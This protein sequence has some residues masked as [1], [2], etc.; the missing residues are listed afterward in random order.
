MRINCFCIPY[1][2][3]AHSQPCQ[4]RPPC[5]GLPVNS[6]PRKISSSTAPEPPVP[7][8]PRP[9]AA[10]LE[11]LLA[12]ALALA[13]VLGG[14]TRALGPPWVLT[15]LAVAALLFVLGR[16]LHLEARALEAERRL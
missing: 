12:L 4:L 11:G 15:L 13:A 6:D 10:S 9:A 7:R 2:T 1:Q 3:T 16:S 8:F 5:P 14:I